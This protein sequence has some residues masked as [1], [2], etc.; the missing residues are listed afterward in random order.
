MLDAGMTAL[1]I[2]RL[3]GIKGFIAIGL[4]LA[5][6]GMWIVHKHDAGTIEALRN[7]NAA[8]ES[9]LT[10]SNQSIETLKAVIAQKNAEA[11]A[12]AD[13]FKASEKQA[14]ADA[15]RLARDGV[16]SQG[17]IDRLRALAAAEAEKPC[18]VP[19]ELSDALEGL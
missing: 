9:R 19:G 15:Q 8:T 18:P 14:Q 10:I 12:R 17:Q 2:A 16:R 1:S 3:I 5:L 13:A 11:N 4:A 6:A 7:K